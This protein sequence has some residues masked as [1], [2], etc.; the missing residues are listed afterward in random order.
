MSKIKRDTPYFLEPPKPSQGMSAAQ[1]ETQEN[2]TQQGALTVQ[3]RTPHGVASSHLLQKGST[4]LSLP[5]WWHNATE[6]QY[7]AAP[8]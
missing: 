2:Q 6:P 5:A 1:V 3:G 8:A 4:R 7:D